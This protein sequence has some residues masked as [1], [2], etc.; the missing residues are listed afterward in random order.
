MEATSF[1]LMVYSCHYSNFL[2]LLTL[3]STLPSWKPCSAL[4][5]PP[6]CWFFHTKDHRKLA[7][8]WKRGSSG[9][10]RKKAGSHR[11]HPSAAAH[12]IHWS[13]RAFTWGGASS[14]RATDACAVDILC[15]PHVSWDVHHTIEAWRPMWIFVLW[16]VA[17]HNHKLSCFMQF[18]EEKKKQTRVFFIKRANIAVLH[19]VPPE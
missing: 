10:L 16:P 14:C 9:A 4:L 12:P 11:H 7:V 1:A 15:F 19:A 2:Y 3:F 18:L 5:W 13:V 8:T 17:V 6:T